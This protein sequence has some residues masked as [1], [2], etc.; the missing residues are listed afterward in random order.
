MGLVTVAEAESAGEVAAKEVL[1]LD[2]C[3]D[4]LVNGLLVAG[5]SAGNLLLLLLILELASHK[6]SY[7]AVIGPDLSYISR[8]NDAVHVPRASL[9]A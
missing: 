3:Q 9:P 4:G 8:S 6:P 7:R 2:G 5:A 1:L